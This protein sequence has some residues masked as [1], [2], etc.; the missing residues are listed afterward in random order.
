MFELEKSNM[1]PL[2]L[3]QVLSTYS[4]VFFTSLAKI[5]FY[6]VSQK[7]VPFLTMPKGRGTFCTPIN[8]L[9]EN[10]HDV[11][12]RVNV[13]MVV[14]WH[15]VLSCSSGWLCFWVACAMSSAQWYNKNVCFFLKKTQIYVKRKTKEE[16]NN[17]SN[18]ILKNTH[19]VQHLHCITQNATL[20][21]QGF[22]PKFLNE[23]E[24]KWP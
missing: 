2:I 22:M 16:K 3:N 1:N 10:F 4:R 18:I 23:L 5:A 8:F 14:L 20:S 7:F 12:M 9:A 13:S 19:Q 24:K 11:H 21:K 6:K 17:I 15:G